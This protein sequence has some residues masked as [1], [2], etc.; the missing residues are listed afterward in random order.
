MTQ[1]AIISPCKTRCLVPVTAVRTEY[2]YI[3]WINFLVFKGLIVILWQHSEMLHHETWRGKR[4]WWLVIVLCI[5]EQKL[6]LM[7]HAQTLDLVFQ[8][9]GRVHLYRRG[10]QFSRLLATE[11][12]GSAVVMLDRRCPIQCTT[13]LATPSIRLFLLHFS[14]RAFPCA[15]R[16][17]FC[18][19]NRENSGLQGNGTLSLDEWF[20]P[21]DQCGLVLCQI[22]GTAEG[23]KIT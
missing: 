23:E 8:R 10:C 4:Y 17:R 11:V 15:I 14:T 5:V 20:K 18:S 16:F 19:N 2:L 3:I 12:C 6:N 21:S 1:A 22:E 13:V 7:A 9:N